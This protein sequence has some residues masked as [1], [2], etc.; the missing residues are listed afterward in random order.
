MEVAALLTT[1]NEAN[2]RVSMHATRRELLEAQAKAAVL[3]LWTV[4]LPSPCTNA[5]YEA[6]MAAAC[7]RTA[8]SGVT[9]IAFGDLFLEDFAHIGSAICGAP[10]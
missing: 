7:R 5:D 6:R 4:P 10:V 2:G 9:S 1:V 8:E 3:P